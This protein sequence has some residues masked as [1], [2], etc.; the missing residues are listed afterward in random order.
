ML[1]ENARDALF[2]LQQARDA[3]AG[4]AEAQELQRLNKTL[5]TKATR[6]LEM[7]GRVKLLHQYGVPLSVGPDTRAVKQAVGNL[8]D[9]FREAPSVKTLTQGNRL[10]KVMDG[11]GGLG[12]GIDSQL[13]QDWKEYFSN[14]LFAGAPPEKRKATLVQTPENKKAIDRYTNL[15]EIFTRYRTTVPVTAEELEKILHVSRELEMITFKEDV[16]DN[17]KRFFDAVATG[18]GASLELLTHDVIDWLRE[19]KLLGSYVAR[20]KL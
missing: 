16:P 4:F 2:R 6:V 5:N 17:V 20:A 11:L 14:Q 10:T 1:L 8:A 7:V 13:R 15:Y 19:N 12:D 18:S 3:Q 9:R